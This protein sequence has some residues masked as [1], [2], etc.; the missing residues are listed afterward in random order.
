[1]PRAQHLIVT[2]ANGYIGQRLVELAR[3]SDR[4]VTVLVRGAPSCPGAIAWELGDG[5]PDAAVDRKL[6]ASAQAIVHL[7]HDWRNTGG[8]NAEANLNRTGTKRLAAAARAAGVRFVF[9]SSQSSR[10]GAANIYGR[11]K[12][13]I[14]QELSA[15]SEVSARVGLVYGGP[16]KAQYGLL[17]RLVGLAP[18]LPMVDPWREVQPIHV[19][20][21]AAGLLALADNETSGWIGLAGTASLPFGKFLKALAR[22]LHGKSLP[23]VP[24]PLRLALLACDATAKLPLV[25]TVDRERVLGLAGFVPMPCADHLKALGLTIRPLEIGLAG[26]PRARRLRI[27]DARAGLR[28]VLGRRPGLDLLRRGVRAVEVSDPAAAAVIPTLCRIAPFLLRAIEPIGGHAPLKRRLELFAALAEASPEGE[29]LLRGENTPR[30]L[31]LAKA[32][33]HLMGETILFPIRTMA[34][35]CQWRPDRKR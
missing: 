10:E 34:T 15:P 31:R 13:A 17:C 28:Y 24:V 27:A 35:V 33:G 6:P 19:D 16:L 22:H 18:V 29:S 12:W 32:G 26:E 11:T 20:E 23:I 2:G 5:L 21:V 30:W 14:E 25:P 3:H 8:E 9:V 7:A 4:R 1:V